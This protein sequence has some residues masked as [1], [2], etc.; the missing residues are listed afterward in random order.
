[1]AVE[2][3]TKFAL[4]LVHSALYADAFLV[5]QNQFL[6]APEKSRKLVLDAV[7]S[8]IEIIDSSFGVPSEL[9]R[10]TDISPDSDIY[11]NFKQLAIA[12]ANSMMEN[13][14]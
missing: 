12:I 9:L 3:G 8:A 14:S 4:E 7:K 11:I 13:E 10:P 5:F 1:M 2:F 6:A